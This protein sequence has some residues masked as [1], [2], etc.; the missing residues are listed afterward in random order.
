MTMMARVRIA[1]LDN[2]A[3]INDTTTLIVEPEQ[4]KKLMLSPGVPVST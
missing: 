1:C 3:V 4:S 2:G